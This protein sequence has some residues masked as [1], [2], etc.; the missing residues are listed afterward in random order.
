MIV[1]IIILQTYELYQFVLLNNCYESLLNHYTI[2][3]INILS[4]LVW[5]VRRGSG[6]KS[7]I[8]IDTSSVTNGTCEGSGGVDC[9]WGPWGSWSACVP[10]TQNDPGMLYTTQCA[11]GI[12][13]PILGLYIRALPRTG[14]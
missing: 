8:A 9:V 14:D 10:Q 6:D 3:V 1:R 11:Q 13:R 12:Y 7:D 4:Q 2:I 5:E